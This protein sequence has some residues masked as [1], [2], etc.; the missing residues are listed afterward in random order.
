MLKNEF[1][2]MTDIHFE[3]LKKHPY[4]DFIEY[5]KV[6][7]LLTFNIK[8]TIDFLNQARMEDIEIASSVMKELV[9]FFKSQELLDIFKKF[10][11][12]EFKDIYTDSYDEDV[13]ECQY[14]LDNNIEIEIPNK[15]WV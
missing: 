9:A 2:K 10:T 3:E 13:E 4:V 15:D 11:G 8:D 5:R 14:I 12:K 1:M 6:F 7:N